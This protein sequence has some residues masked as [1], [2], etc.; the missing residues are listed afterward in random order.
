M[1]THDFSG[2]TSSELSP[3]IYEGLTCDL[4]DSTDIIETREGYTCRDCG[5]V[6]ETQKLEYHRPYNIEV[7]QHA[8]LGSTQIGFKKERLRSPDS[9]RLEKLNKLHSTK[10][11]GEVVN[12]KARSEIS[13]ILASLSYSD[14]YK[15][16]IF[17]KFADIRSRLDAGTKYRNPEKLIPI[18][19]F[20]CLKMQNVSV[21]QV[22]LL[23]FSKIS[24]KDF[25]KFKYQ[26]KTFV[27]EYAERNRQTCVLDRVFEVS[28]HFQLGMPYYYQSKAILLKLWDGIKCTKDDVIAG[29]VASITALCSYR[30]KVTVSAICDRLGIRM[31]TIQAQ[32]KKRI[33]ER[34]R[35]PGF[36]SLI[37]SADLLKKVV[38]KMG[39]LGVNE[40]LKEQVLSEEVNSVDIV[41][42]KLGNAQQVFN[43]NN[44]ND[45]YFFALKVNSQRV[46]LLALNLFDD[47]SVRTDDKKITK[48][49]L[50]VG[51]SFNV[52]MFNYFN[53]GPPLV[54][55]Y[56]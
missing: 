18:V 34:F 33:F 46:L 13:R 37:K 47:T 3:G 12:I 48:N 45:Y 38:E 41:E 26:L 7:L 21:N 15:E 2:K 27:P 24:K 50:L 42:V 39:I 36:L 9:R 20:A 19:I 35:V 1:A 23:K 8:V 49:I 30:D 40:G 55:Q 25:N 16:E 14:S 54:S 52:N 5:I 22:E 51:R 17:K 31:S 6:L 53:K 4:C 29:L 56:C 44:N 10:S 43:S 11:N 32:V 28:E